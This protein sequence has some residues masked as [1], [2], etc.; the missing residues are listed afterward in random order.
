MRL[1]LRVRSADWGH[2]A[3]LL[4]F[5]QMSSSLEQ[6]MCDKRDEALRANGSR[7]RLANGVLEGELEASQLALQVTFDLQDLA[8]VSWPAGLLRPPMVL[9][10]SGEEHVADQC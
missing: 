4:F 3:L 1:R 7:A 2:A 8:A 5:T 6:F 9:V 10:Y